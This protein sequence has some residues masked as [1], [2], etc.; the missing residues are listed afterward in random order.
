MEL[1]TLTTSMIFASILFMGLGCSMGC[2][3]VNTPFMLGS[4]LGDGHDIHESR[5]A[6]MLF[7]LGKVVALSM[8][9]L[10]AATFGTIV[11]DAIESVY[12]SATRW[13]IQIATFALGARIIYLTLKKPAEETTVSSA[14]AGCAPSS[15]ASCKS[16]CGPKPTPVKSTKK[17]PKSYFFAGMLYS[18][19]PCA[20]LST[21]LIYASTM[22]PL[23]GM[24]LLGSFGIVNSII[25]V[26]VYASLIGI[27]NREFSENSKK[28]LKYV[29]L[30]GGII[31]IFAAIFK[32]QVTI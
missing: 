7:S 8:Y 17:M 12:P 29:K 20:P 30:S 31:L 9:G 25:P 10:L 11:L 23:M 14:E 6:M 4:L 26:F 24:L 2:G 13:I 3:T 21:S 19:I 15:C 1:E 22:T 5:R 18:A 27:A 16:G 32:V 28:Y